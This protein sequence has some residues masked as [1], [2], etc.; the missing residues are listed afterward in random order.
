MKPSHSIE[1]SK[2]PLAAVRYEGVF[3]DLKQIVQKRFLRREI[4]EVFHAVDL[5]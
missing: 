4:I 3:H 5:A 2:N 1:T